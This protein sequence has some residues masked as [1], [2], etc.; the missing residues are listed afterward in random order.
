MSTMTL[1][2]LASDALT[3]T[4][5]MLHI[6]TDGITRGDFTHEQSEPIMNALLELRSACCLQASDK[7]EKVKVR[8]G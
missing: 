6:F 7:R 8:R 3:E 2:K 4:D 1:R 5:K